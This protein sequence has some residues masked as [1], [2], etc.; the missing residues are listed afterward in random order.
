MLQIITLIH[1][2]RCVDIQIVRMCPHRAVNVCT[3]NIQYSPYNTFILRAS[4]HIQHVSEQY[5]NTEFHIRVTVYPN[6][7]NDILKNDE[8]FLHQRSGVNSCA[9][10]SDVINSTS[11]TH[12]HTQKSTCAYHVHNFKKSMSAV[13]LF[14]MRSG[15]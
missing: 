13:F 9:T 7:V 2:V 4:A 15:V 6:V 5:P 12:R 8:P 11:R 14:M 1:V 3:F 10:I